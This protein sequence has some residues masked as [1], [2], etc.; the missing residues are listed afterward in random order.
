MARSSITCS[1]VSEVDLV[2]SSEDG[3]LV[4]VRRALTHKAY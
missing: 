4:K 1:S 3:V 2:S